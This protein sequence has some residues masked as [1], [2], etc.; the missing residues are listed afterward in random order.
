MTT[1]TIDEIT[2]IE[3]IEKIECKNCRAWEFGCFLTQEDID[4]LR[5]L[6]TCLMCNADESEL[7]ITAA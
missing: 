3:Q 7:V 6:H 2:K 1:I 5:K 4:L